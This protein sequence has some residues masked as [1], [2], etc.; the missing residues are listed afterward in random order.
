MSAGATE[1]GWVELA[2][3]AAFML[4]AGIVSWKFELGQGKRIAVATLRCFL[5]LLACGFLLGYLFGCQTWWLVGLVVLGMALAATQ[6]A[7]GRVRSRVAGLAVPV[8]LSIA[9]SSVAVALVVVEGVVHAEPWY[10]ARTLVPIAGM[11]LGNAMSSV[12]VAID[13]LFS[14]LDARTDEMFSLVAL[15]ATPRE[16]ALPSIRTSVRAGMTPTLAT[17]SAAGLVSIPGMM[18]GQILAGAD[19]MLAAK[20]QIVV[21]MMITAANTVSI[22]LACFLT[23]RKRF[24]RIEGYYIDP[25]LRPSAEDAGTR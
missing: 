12:A 16:A 22:V 11:V 13:R 2:C 8:F 23:Y 10:D 14:D 7:V 1:I 19:P 6:I 15:G 9:L 3:A 20:Y 24:D 18:S 25:G 17:M 5:Q 21:L 4:A